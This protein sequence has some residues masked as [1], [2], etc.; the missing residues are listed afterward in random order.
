MRHRSGSARAGLGALT[1]VLAIALLVAACGGSTSSASS[2]P[3]PSPS[4]TATPFVPATPAP[5]PEGWQRRTVTDLGFR[6]D[7]PADWV[8][9]KLGAQTTVTSPDGH[10][11]IFYVANAAPADGTLDDY[12]QANLA[13]F[14]ADPEWQDSVSIGGVE[15]WGV[16]LHLTSLGKQYFVIDYFT[17]HAGRSYDFIMMSTPGTEAADR[18]LY[19]QIESTL[20]FT[21]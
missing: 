7:Y 18:T 2:T 5:P 19:Q 9:A 11:S 10:A 8:D 1:L 12:K 17:V 16:E 6:F 20:A 13:S 3:T 15:G 4:P 14:G 21:Q